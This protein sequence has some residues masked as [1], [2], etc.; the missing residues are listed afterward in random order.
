VQLATDVPAQLPPVQAY[1]VGELLQLTVSIDVPPLVIDAGVAVTV[2]TGTGGS[3]VTVA[4]AAVPVPPA[5][6]PA[7]V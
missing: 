5:L 1:E 3:T 2:Q 4:L 6:T 7:T